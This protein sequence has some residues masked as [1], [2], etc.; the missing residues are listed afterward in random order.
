MKT[1]KLWIVCWFG[2]LALFLAC[3]KS[4]LAG[5][6]S[7]ESGNPE[8]AG[9]LTL[10]GGEPVV[11]AWVYCV[12]QGHNPVKS[13]LD[14]LFI[15]RSDSLGGYQ[16]FGLPA[17]H[18]ALEAYDSVTQ[19]RLLV[20]NVRID[21]SATAVIRDSLL[22]TGT[23]RLGVSGVSEGQRAWVAV[24]GTQLL[25]PVVVR[26]GSV[27]VDSLPA[28]VLGELLFYTDTLATPVVFPSTSPVI[29]G[30]TVT[31]QAPPI[32]FS[33][34]FDL[35]NDGGTLGFIDTLYE[36]P[37]AL[38]LDSTRM[39]FSVA[40]WQ[41]GRLRLW[42]SDSTREMVYRVGHWDATQKEALL[43]VR[44]DTLLPPQ[45]S[46][47]ILLHWDESQPAGLPPGV[48][49]FAASN[50]FLAVWHLEN[51]EAPI[52][53]DGSYGFHGW[54]QGV[55]PRSGAVGNALWFD[56]RQS[57][58]SIPSSQT[59]LLDF[60]F[61]DTLSASVWVRLDNPNTSRFVFGKGVYQYYLKYYYP[62][63]WLFELCDNESYTRRHHYIAEHDSLWESG[64]WE[65]LTVVQEGERVQL[66]VNGDLKDSIVAIG[67]HPDSVARY[68]GSSFEIGRRLFPDL[69]YDQ[70]FEGMIDEL[71][72][73]EK[74]YSP[75]WVQ[76][77]YS[78]Q[79]PR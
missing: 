74:A 2:A 79:R 41:T 27:F 57:Y 55:E 11:A 46:Q 42:N 53:D 58:V 43:W 63:G 28:G 61:Q 12:P 72:L 26:Y 78:N 73:S 19:M 25:R 15:Q 77:L 22:P 67:V 34:R 47:K 60:E 59:G 52:V 37:L 3:A 29:P 65:F 20:R 51:A 31:W 6:N 71:W 64:R 54:P 44:M 7:A 50:G 30:D 10:P 40:S 39:D 9:V 45:D 68:T 13:S 33:K 36:F 1:Q 69:S 8:L 4:E 76:R 17:G 56:G 49:P 38:R 16:F 62:I 75:Q 23:L 48:S 66:Y 18:Y 32:S 21:S 70:L 5:G 14:S 24:S 35:V